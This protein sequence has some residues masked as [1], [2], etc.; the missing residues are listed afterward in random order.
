MSDDHPGNGE[1]WIA[2]AVLLFITIGG[3]GTASHWLPPEERPCTG[4]LSDTC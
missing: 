3:C 2:I 1:I 4:R